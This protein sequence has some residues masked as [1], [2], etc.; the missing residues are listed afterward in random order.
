L[1]AAESNVRLDRDVVLTL[2]DESAGEAR[3]S[4]MEQDGARY[5][6]LRYRPVLSLGERVES[7]PRAWVFLFESAGDRDPLLARAQ[8]DVIRALLNQAEPDD[9]F[10]ALTAGTRTR[11]FGCRLEKVTPENIA[12]ALAFLESS[13]LIGALD[14]G[15]ALTDAEPFLKAG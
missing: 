1:D 4:S 12:K 11:A 15:K 5:L 2:S 6:M 14:L 3:F 9:T 8:I 10:T 7:G 13:H